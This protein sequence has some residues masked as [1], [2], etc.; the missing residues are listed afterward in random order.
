[1]AWTGSGIASLRKAV[2]YLEITVRS[3]GSK[4]LKWRSRG[5]AFDLPIGT[6]VGQPALRQIPTSDVVARMPQDANATSEAGHQ[7][8]ELLIN[9]QASGVLAHALITQTAAR[10]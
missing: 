5:H 6:I 1:M 10:H 2:V 8:D 3:V 7:V 9:Q 4:P